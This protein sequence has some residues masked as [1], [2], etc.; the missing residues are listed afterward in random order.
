MDYTSYG[1]VL[2]LLLTWYNVSLILFSLLP[3]VKKHLVFPF[4][5]NPS[6]VQSLGQKF[7]HK[8]KMS[9]KVLDLFGI[10]VKLRI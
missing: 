10:V 1:A 2:I 5:P 3:S 9:H 6:Q 4:V 8:L 7:L